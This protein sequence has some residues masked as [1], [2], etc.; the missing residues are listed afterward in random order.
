MQIGPAYI[1]L[2]ANRLLLKLVLLIENAGVAEFCYDSFFPGPSRR[3]SRII[4]LLPR[5]CLF[6]NITTS[7][8]S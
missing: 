7:E 3:A 2:M 1:V 8:R 6:I 4:P 5:T